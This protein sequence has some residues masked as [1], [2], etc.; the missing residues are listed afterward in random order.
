[1]L[2]DSEDVKVAKDVMSE[3]CFVYI[4]GYIVV[5][6]RLVTCIHAH[7]MPLPTGLVDI[8]VC[9]WWEKILAT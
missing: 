7:V 6:N 1:M 4:V 9:Y 3:V 8:Q 5:L 2:V